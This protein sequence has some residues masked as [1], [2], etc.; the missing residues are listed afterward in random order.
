MAQAEVFGSAQLITGPAGLLADRA[1][2]AR[3]RAAQLA[4]P[5]AEVHDLE[6]AGLERGHFT[7]AV[8]GSLLSSYTI[9]TLRGIQDLPADLAS[10]VTAAASWP[11]AELCLTLMHPGGVKGKALLDSLK[12]AKVPT[13]KVQEPKTWELP[14]F[15][16][17]EGRRAGVR[18]DEEA[19]R[20]LVDAV[21]T[22][23]R[24]L[25]GAVTQLA[26]D[27]EGA[28]VTPEVIRRY[29]SGRAEVSSFQVCDDVLNGRTGQ[30]LEKLRWTLMTGSSTP[31]MI[32]SAFAAS[33]RG[34][35]KYLDLR[36]ARLAENELARQVGV[37]P[38]KLKDL[39]RQARLWSPAGVASAIQAVALAD[40][41]VK[42]AA[43]DPG[44]ALEHLV[45]AIQAARTQR[46]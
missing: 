46:G 39:N 24:A 5:E 33:L 36:G 23:L 40:G 31:V 17:A 7:E 16:A 8:G 30:G 26:S 3:V 2:V 37:P 6:A 34:L 35:G 27:W 21:G 28:G 1:V 15:I 38:W 14:K 29:F 13:L 44:F 19:G 18:F 25:A 20:A 11:H 9:V 41:Q 12:K 10:V 4:Q 45:L 32:T 22:D 42:G 43:T